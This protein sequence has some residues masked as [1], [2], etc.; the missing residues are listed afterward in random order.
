M[1]DC[2]AGDV[3]KVELSIASLLQKE[4]QKEDEDNGRATEDDRDDSG[5]T[6]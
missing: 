4:E 5:E 2:S 6:S 3:S 1:K